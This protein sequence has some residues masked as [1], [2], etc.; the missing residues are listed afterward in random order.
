MLRGM[1]F[2]AEWNRPAFD[3]EVEK[4]VFRKVN[5]LVRMCEEA[6]VLYL[7]ENFINFGGWSCL[8]TL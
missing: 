5:E 7:H 4:N 3:P 6:G 1:S 8:V 2:K